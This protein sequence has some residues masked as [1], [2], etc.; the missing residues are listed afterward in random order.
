MP[1]GQGT[2]GNGGGKRGRE[3]DETLGALGGGVN[4]FSGEAGK[5]VPGWTKEPVVVEIG[6]VAR[7]S[8]RYSL[9]EE[10]A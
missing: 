10:D 2:G 7:S 8:N 6:M 4:G 3:E 5:G 1:A 9:T